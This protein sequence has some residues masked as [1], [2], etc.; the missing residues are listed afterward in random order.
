MTRKLYNLK[1]LGKWYQFLRLCQKME[2]PRSSNSFKIITFVHR[3]NIALFT[4][5]GRDNT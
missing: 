4:L 2:L 5:D 1:E 3:D